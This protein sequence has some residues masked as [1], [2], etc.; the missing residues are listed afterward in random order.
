MLSQ[1]KPLKGHCLKQSWKRPEYS[2]Q[3]VSCPVCYMCC[4]HCTAVFKTPLTFHR[5]ST[6]WIRGDKPGDAEVVQL[7]LGFISTWSQMCAFSLAVATNVCRGFTPWSST[8]L[9]HT[10]LLA[11]SLAHDMRSCELPLWGTVEWCFFFRDVVNSFSCV[12]DWPE[13][14]E[15]HLGI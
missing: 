3:P 5:C 8:V 12:S 11:L 14:I 7:L 13:T 2:F 15:I 10:V 4:G 6:S 1:D 9:T